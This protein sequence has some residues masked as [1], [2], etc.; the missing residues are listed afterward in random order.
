MDHEKQMLIFPVINRKKALK[1]E[2]IF[3]KENLSSRAIT[4]NTNYK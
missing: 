2:T 1:N 4:S 3:L